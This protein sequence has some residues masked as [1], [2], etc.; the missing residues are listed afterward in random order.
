MKTSFDCTLVPQVTCWVSTLRVVPKR[1][2]TIVW[3]IL[4]LKVLGVYKFTISDF[5]TNLTSKLLTW[6]DKSKI[7]NFFYWKFWE[8]RYLHLVIWK[9]VLITYQKI[10]WLRNMWVYKLVLVL[11][12]FDANLFT[13]KSLSISNYLQGGSLAITPF[14]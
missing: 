7:F 10:L 8:L 2:H 14:Y 4:L 1:R 13:E 6:E 3:W 11:I 9:L 12:S 5:E